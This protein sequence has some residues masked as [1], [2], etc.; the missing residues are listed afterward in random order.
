MAVEIERK[1]L[2]VGDTWRSGATGRAYRQGY[3]PTRNQVTV[4]VRIVSTTGYLT[5]KGP[6]EGLSRSEFEYEIPLTD[7]QQLLDEL[8]DRPL[9][10]KIRY[11][12]EVGGTRWEIDEFGGDNAGLILAEVELSHPDQTF[13]R[14]PWLGPEVSDDP[15]Y[16][17]A[18]LAQHP[19]CQWGNQQEE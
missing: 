15:R 16:F 17:N 13:E 2:V 12:V 19:Y 5:I 8:C 10:E 14:P 9:I 6:T 11:V 18:R 3:L 7:A 4:R 1:F